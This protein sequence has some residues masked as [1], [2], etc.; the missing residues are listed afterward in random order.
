MLTMWLGRWLTLFSTP[1]MTATS[2]L[3]GCYHHVD[4]KAAGTAAAAAATGQDYMVAVKDNVPLY[5]SGPQQFGLPDQLLNKDDLVWV[6]KKQFGFTLVQTSEGQLGWLPTE[7][8]AS[9][10]SETLVAAG[11]AYEGPSPLSRS[12]A[13]RSPFGTKKSIHRRTSRGTPK[14]LP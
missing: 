13:T 12:R 10:P 6:I 11:P 8:L 5:A 9:V 1:F 3:T 14:L 4:P 2:I 7:D